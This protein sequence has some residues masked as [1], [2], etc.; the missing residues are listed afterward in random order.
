MKGNYMNRSLVIYKHETIIEQASGAFGKPYALVHVPDCEEIAGSG[1]RHVEECFRV[2][3]T[4]DG[5]RHSKAFKT[6]PE[7]RA[8]F[9]RW[10]K[11]I[12]EEMSA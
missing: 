12:I 1:T 9:E 10:T 4:F 11:P 7:A 2:V 8:E 5:D 6:L 3:H